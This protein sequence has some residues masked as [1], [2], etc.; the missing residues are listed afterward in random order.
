M[1][2]K[3]KTVGESVLESEADPRFPGGMNYLDWLMNVL[4]PDELTARN[5]EEI[6]ADIRHRRESADSGVKPKKHESSARVDRLMAKL[7]KP[8]PKFGMRGF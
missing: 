2:N 7:S 6:V 8:K 3:S 4:P 5:L 1:V